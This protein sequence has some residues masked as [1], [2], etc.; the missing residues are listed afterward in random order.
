[1]TTS[2]TSSGGKRLA[3][4]SI[5]GTR[6]AAPG[7]D[8]KFYPGL[9]QAM[10]TSAEEVSVE[11]SANGDNVYSV[12]FDDTRETKEFRYK[13]TYFFMHPPVL[14]IFLSSSSSS[15]PQRV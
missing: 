15:P 5:V 11:G 3:K 13:R 12:R 10:K 4:R 14:R 6:V 1:M 2:S 9:I 8:G 7:E